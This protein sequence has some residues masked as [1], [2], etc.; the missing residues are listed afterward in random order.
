M[1]TNCTIMMVHFIYLCYQADFVSDP[2]SLQYLHFQPPCPGQVYTAQAKTSSDGGRERITLQMLVLY[3]H[4]HNV[5]CIYIYTHI[6]MCV[7]VCIYIY[8]YVNIF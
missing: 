1:M 2:Q 4:D 8:I 3:F 6:D 5:H 7:C